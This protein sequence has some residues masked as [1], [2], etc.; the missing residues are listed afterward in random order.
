VNDYYGRLD[1]S[2][3][4]LQTWLGNCG[5]TLNGYD[6]NAPT[7]S[8]DA[9]A[10]SITGA[11]GNLCSTSVSPTVTVRNGGTSTLTSFTVNWS[12]PGGPSGSTP[13]TGSL[14]SG[15]TTTVSL[16]SITLPA[17]IL[18]LSATVASPNGGTDLAPGNNT[19][20]S[21]FVHG[22]NQ[23]TFN[24]TLDR[25]G[26]ETSWLIRSGATTLA[27]GGPYTNA[28]ANGAYPQTPITICL[29]DGC[30]E[31]VV[32]DSY[33]DGL[34]CAYGNGAF[35][36]TGASGTLATGG[37]FTTSSVS[38]FCVETSASSLVN[39]RVY[40]DG[41]YG[42][43]PLMSDGLRTT[44]QIPL[45]EPY[46]A[47]GFTNVGGGSETTTAGVL[48]TTGNNAIVDWVFL[49]LRGAAP[50]YTVLATRCALLQRDGD[51]VDVNG[52]SPVSFAIA[53]GNY[54]V[55]VRHRNHLGVMSANTVA[56]GP[57]GGSIDFT[58]AATATYGTDARRTV[59]SV[60]TMWTGDC[61]SDGEILYSGGG[62]DRDLI[63][64]RIGG[65]VPT[66]SVS[67]YLREDVNLDG[68]VLYTGG[69]NDRDLI[70]QAI[71]GVVPTNN[72]LEQ[73]P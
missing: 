28:A 27:S 30:Y 22:P 34:C 2:F 4:L 17:G 9:Q 31:L 65:S 8:L 48:A 73:L 3:P 70:L 63:L 40:L 55:V 49:E 32:N 13:W 71:G 7:V 23:V 56:I 20:T 15:N 33:G 21:N 53:T 59:G 72:R 46:T 12:I 41:P 18:T 44:S 35:T 42:A 5:N 66:N 14:T 25:Y 29:P 38:A 69:G 16:G 24:L 1:L 67:G 43:G 64:V 62:N 68:S 19:A 54:H 47:L 36:L 50:T 57:T 52:T 37:T 61:S 51:I 26:S 11:S 6:P 10:I 39:T 60:R 58:N 45:T